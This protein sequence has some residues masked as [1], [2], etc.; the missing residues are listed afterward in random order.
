VEALTVHDAPAIADLISE[1][2]VA[3]S[4]TP[5]ADLP[6][7]PTRFEIKRRLADYTRKVSRA[8]ER[9]VVLEV[10]WNGVPEAGEPWRQL[11]TLIADTAQAMEDL[12]ADEM[13]KAALVRK[14]ERV[15]LRE[16]TE[17]AARLEGGVLIVTARLAFGT[18]GRLGSTALK[19]AI[20]RI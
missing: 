11:A 3:P 18:Q 20:E 19:Q 5:A 9:D 8:L 7:P 10:D 4:A 6:P 1:D 14:I 2:K 12:A 16:G 15:R 17:A 13:G